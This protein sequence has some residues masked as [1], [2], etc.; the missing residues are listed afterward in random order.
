MKLEN[1][2]RGQREQYKDCHCGIIQKALEL[3][4][5][6]QESSPGPREGPRVLRSTSPGCSSCKTHVSVKVS[7]STH[8]HRGQQTTA[9]T[10]K[11]AEA[12]EPDL[13]QFYNTLKWL[14]CGCAD[15]PG[16]GKLCTESVYSS[17]SS[18]ACIFIRK[19]CQKCG[20]Y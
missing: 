1:Q 19:F 20:K 9:G 8:R 17:L 11:P 13:S 15:I 12:S 6:Q 4:E 10:T 2:A 14:F 7:A 16:S 5:R 18:F 3:G